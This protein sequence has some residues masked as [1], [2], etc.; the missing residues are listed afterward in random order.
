MAVLLDK[1]K[2]LREILDTIKSKAKEYEKVK[3]KDLAN[4]YLGELGGLETAFYIVASK[5]TFTDET[6]KINEEFRKE[7]ERLR[8]VLVEKIA[9][10]SY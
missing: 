2:I 5:A 7:H 6:S 4:I 10:L 9:I 1:D 3:S 8:Q